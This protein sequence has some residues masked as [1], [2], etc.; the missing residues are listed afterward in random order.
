[1]TEPSK[2][3][4]IPAADWDM[5]A[6]GSDGHEAE[7]TPAADKPVEVWANN[8][9]GEPVHY[10]THQLDGTYTIHDEAVAKAELDKAK[11][12]AALSAGDFD[13]LLAKYT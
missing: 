10:A 6:N 13:R 8:A 4:R 3:T 9:A 12:I 2:A 7:Y 5:S 1:M 11:T